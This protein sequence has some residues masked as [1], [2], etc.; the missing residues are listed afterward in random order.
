M[1]ERRRYRMKSISGLA[2]TRL[3]PFEWGSRPSCYYC[4]ALATSED[5]TTPVAMLE[6]IGLMSSLERPEPQIVPACQSCNS[7]LGDRYF[8][9][10]TERVDF[11]KLRLVQKHAELLRAPFWSDE[12][13]DK[14]KGGLKGK[15]QRKQWQRDEVVE[16]I[17]F[18]LTLQRLWG[19]SDWLG[20]VN[21]ELVRTSLYLEAKRR[22]G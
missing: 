19:L 10:I 8:P 6:N 11:V 16:R 21:R 15:V 13:M 5:H 14:L 1:S 17:L 22:E 7:M 12:E 3:D 9:T 2:F 20:P 18:G 4:G